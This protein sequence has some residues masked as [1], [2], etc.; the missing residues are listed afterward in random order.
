MQPTELS[1]QPADSAG[2]TIDE[3]L[4]QAVAHHGVGRL[5][6]A[7]RLYRFI[8]QV[9]PNHSDANHNLGVLAT[10]SGQL[11]ASLP[12][13]KAALD[14][15]PNHGQYWI[16]YID[17]LLR[18]GQVENARAVLLQGRRHGL[19]G[20]AVDRLVSALTPAETQASTQAEK[21]A[22]S[23]AFNDG[24]YAQAERLAMSM[25]RVHPR[26]AFAW[27]VLGAAL[28]QTGRTSDALMPMQKSVE[29]LPD[30]AEAHSNLAVALTDLG[31]LVE[32]EAH[33]AQ[34]LAI[35]PDSAEAHSNRGNVLRDLGRPDEAEASCRQAIAIKPDY[36]EAHN[37]LGNALY[38]LG[39]FTP[40]ENW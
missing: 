39:M 3:A 16:S 18:A 30:D 15:S 22:L 40:A 38:A 34:A 23:R 21:D 33:C 14:A 20:D 17:A 1:R 19:E 7:E 12:L 8:L 27:K 29:L 28:M 25:T 5:Q 31:R 2:L 10:Q 6:D 32:A 26:D 11:D 24:N 36:P 9:Q 35:K 4:R 13:L 37:N